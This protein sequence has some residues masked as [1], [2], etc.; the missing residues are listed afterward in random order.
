MN[1]TELSII[2]VSYNTK[3]L[4]KN[5]ILSLRAKIKNIS[6]EIII[7]D[8][9]SKD[10]S[11]KMIQ[12]EFP[13][14]RL[15][16]NKK[17]LGF[18]KA[19]NLA[20]KIAKGK[21]VALVNSDTEIIK[22]KTRAAI[23]YME[24]NPKIGILGPKILLSNGRIQPSATFFKNIFSSFV[25]YSH[26]KKFMPSDEMR[27]III[28]NFGKILPKTLLKYLTVYE[29][30]GTIKIVDWVSATFV[31]IRKEVFKSIGYF[32]ENYFMYSED[33]DLG[34]RAKRANWISIYYPEFEVLHRLE[35]SGKGNPLVMIERQRSSLL[36]WYKFHPQYKVLIIKFIM[37]LHFMPKYIFGLDKKYKKAYKE[38]LKYIVK[39]EKYLKKHKILGK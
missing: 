37:L 26:L 9:C 6:Y 32:D 13:N 36:Y 20:I 33:E 3:Q 31:I 4:L 8:N 35:A 18:G 2:V 39:N 15:I 5:C 11:P 34:L 29:K 25:H 38:I 24:K 22:D 21:Y 14:I 23:K 16:K 7:V 19:N 17:N 10:G 27:K 28:R 12:D 30:K 1:K